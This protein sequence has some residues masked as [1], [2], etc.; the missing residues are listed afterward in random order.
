LTMG[1]SADS[2]LDPCQLLWHGWCVEA[3]SAQELWSVVPSAGRLSRVS[4]PVEPPLAVG[5]VRTPLHPFAQLLARK[6][7]EKQRG[8]QVARRVSSA[9]N[10]IGGS[11]K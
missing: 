9:A 3:P 11:G 6:R 8:L 2:E 4:M 5:R 1:A 7:L 10:R